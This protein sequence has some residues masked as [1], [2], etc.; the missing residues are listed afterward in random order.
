MIR[1]P[2]R[3]KAISKNLMPLDITK[4]EKQKI[5]L[6]KMEESEIQ[7]SKINRRDFVKSAGAGAAVVSLD[8]LF[9]LTNAR[10]AA[11]SNENTAAKKPNVVIIFCDQ[12][13]SFT[14]GC[15]GNQ[16]VKTP[17]IDRLAKNGFKFEQCITNGPVSVSARSSLLSGQY[18]RTS[19][20]SRANEMSKETG[21]SLFERNDRMKF[22]D[23]TIAEEF[24]K[25]G[26]KTAQIGKWH[27]DTRPSLAGFDESLVTAGNIFTNGS[28][29][30]N[31]EKPYPVPG[32]TTD[33]ET[34]MAK[35]YITANK[36]SDKPFF[37]YYNIISPHMPILHVPYKYSHMYDPKEVPLRD[38]VWKDGVLAHDEQWFHIYMWQTFYNKAYQ[39]LTAK[40]SPDF[41]LRDLTALYYGSVTWVDDTVGEILASLKENGLEDNTIILFTSD[42]G[43]MLGS[44]HMWNKDRLYEEAIRIPM[45]FSW[46]GMIKPDKTSNQIA[47]LID[48]MPTLLDLCGGTIPGN[49]QGQSLMPVLS[50]KKDRLGMEYAFIETPYGEMGIR[51]STHIYGILSNK[52]DTAI[53]DDRYLFYD[54]EEDPYEFKNL[55]KTDKSSAIANDLR[56]RL[57]K[58]DKDTPRLKGLDYKPWAWG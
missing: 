41:T 5:I 2:G 36:N 48:I 10:Q 21:G 47:T 24:R 8:G 12:L 22:K 25:L 31:E 16:F 38:N 19:A 20:G 39:P 55:A 4:H 51:T 29:S 58:W 9:G 13:R 7:K 54:L 40:T 3:I 53:E 56:E 28:F 45:I 26:Y 43:D 14:V 11:I 46:P 33:Y 15:Y 52:E 42:H 57:I 49:V 50:G 27:I 18:S 30:K 1:F 35:E 23:P 32:F 34:I 17:N 37:L 6:I 44:Q